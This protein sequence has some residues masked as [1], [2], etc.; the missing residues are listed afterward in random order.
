MKSLKEPTAQVFG[1]MVLVHTS[2][3]AMRAVEM[4][5]KVDAVS[6][7]LTLERAASDLESA[8]STLVD[9]SD[10]SGAVPATTKETGSD[11]ILQ[12]VEAQRALLVNVVSVVRCMKFS[13]EAGDLAGALD[14][15][16][17]E[18]ERILEAL[19]RPALE[20]DAWRAYKM[21]ESPT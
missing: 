16:E 18:L 7:R 6:L 9:A 5:E 17:L 19:E 1:A 15:V 4:G 21:G 3:S 14:L 2:A 11:S 12:A 13:E 8:H 10:A 20:R